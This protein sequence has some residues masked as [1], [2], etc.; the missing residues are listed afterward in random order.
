MSDPLHWWREALAGRR[1]EIERGH[2]QDGFFRDRKHRAI[3]IWHEGDEQRCLVTRENRK[4]FELQ[5]ADEIDALFGEC[6]QFPVPHEVYDAFVERG[7]PWPAEHLVE[8]TIKETLAAGDDRA[9]AL[10]AKR[11]RVAAAQIEDPDA[12]ENPRATMGGNAPPEP[13]EPDQDL[14]DRVTKLEKQAA[15]WLKS[16]GGVPRTQTEADIAANYKAKFLELEK[17]AVAN[18]KAEKRPILDAA[19][20]VDGKWFPIRD[21]AE[22]LKKQIDG[23]VQTWN[24]AEQARLDA[25]AKAETERLRQAAAA[26]AARN[27][28]APPPEVRPVVAARVTSGTTGRAQGI[29]TTPAVYEI[30]DLAKVAAHLASLGHAG[31]NAVFFDACQRRVN[32]LCR[33]GVAV[34]G[35]VEKRDQAA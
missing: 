2:P 1:G 10:Q 15:A 30:K 35:A 33:A 18:H 20:A 19:D 21:G 14:A 32:E 16:I 17:E 6:C 13:M 31:K 26:E 29:R 7:E 25:L 5:H 28:A 11:E 34:P 12:A 8:L 24:R 23:I 9:S 4:W 3:A 27:P 22:T